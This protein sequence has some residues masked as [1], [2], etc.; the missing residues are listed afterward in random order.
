MPGLSKHLTTFWLC[1]PF[2]LHNA[3]FSIILNVI[4][5][6]QG[7]KTHSSWMLKYT[8]GHFWGFQRGS[9]WISSRQITHYNVL[10]WRAMVVIAACTLTDV[11]EKNSWHLNMRGGKSKEVKIETKWECDAYGL[12]QEVL[13]VA[14]FYAAWTSGFKS[15]YRQRLWR[16]WGTIV[17][18]WQ[19]TAT[20]SG[21]SYI[22]LMLCLLC[23]SWLWDNYVTIVS[24][25]C[26]LTRLLLPTV[27]LLI[28]IPPAFYECSILFLL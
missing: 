2:T 8:V 26:I 25:D 12:E 17:S 19:T 20:H 9:F 7:V 5:C 24:S 22:L 14:L 15:R 13:S 3:R 16:A 28:I 11:R 1:H 27:T 10:Q 4:Y 21:I 6:L 18:I 23:C